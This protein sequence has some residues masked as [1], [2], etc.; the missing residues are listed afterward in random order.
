MGW[1]ACALLVAVP[2][3]TAAQQP[4]VPDLIAAARRLVADQQ[5]DSAAGLLALAADSRAGGTIAQRAQASVLLGVVRYHLGQ[6]SLTVAAFHTAIVLDSTL[7]VRGLGQIDPSL[8]RIF[9]DEQDRVARHRAPPDNAHFCVRG[10]RNGERSPRL[11]TIPRFVVV[12]SGPD[13]INTHA[14]IVVRLIISDEGTP[15]QESI[16]VVSSTMR[17]LDAQ[18]LDA[19]RAAYFQPALAGGVP[20][21]ALVEMTFDF[22]AE[23]MNGLTYQVRG[24]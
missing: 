12:D 8:V 11:R 6:D 5:L 23:G 10:C 13:F 7:E 16:R 14:V 22:R 1:L 9:Q 20:V 24:P 4:S 18:V 15:E 21:R 3:A 2:D 19:V 17:S